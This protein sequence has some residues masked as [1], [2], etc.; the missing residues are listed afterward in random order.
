[1]FYR[2]FS[3]SFESYCQLV[4]LFLFN[5]C[6]ENMSIAESQ[7]LKSAMCGIWCVIVALY[8]Y[9]LHMWMPLNLGIYI[10][11]K[12]AILVGFS[13]GEYKVSFPISFD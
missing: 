4:P 7:I 3:D 1:M 12:D 11:N 13:F 9:I 10:Q 5:F 6:L 2:Y 8:I